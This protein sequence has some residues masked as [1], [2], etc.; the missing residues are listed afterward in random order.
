V[1]ANSYICIAPINFRWR[2]SFLFSQSLDS[3]SKEEQHWTRFWEDRNLRHGDVVY[4]RQGALEEDDVFITRVQEKIDQPR[5]RIAG[6]VVGTIDQMLHGIVTGTDGLHAGV[7]HW[8]KRGSLWRL[9]DTLL[10]CGFEVVLTADHGNV[11]GIG[12]GKPN[13]GATADERGERVHVFPNDLLRSSVAAKYQ[14]S[15]K[16]ESLHW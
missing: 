13:V 2:P 16:W 9:L 3:T 14:G 8:A 10:Q 1:G 7:R 12:I 15:I 11:E 4:A 5:C 6:I